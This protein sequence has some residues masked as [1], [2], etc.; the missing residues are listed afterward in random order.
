MLPNHKVYFN[1]ILS[2]FLTV[3]LDTV[4]VFTPTLTTIST[5][6]TLKAFLYYNIKLHTKTPLIFYYN[7]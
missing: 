3:F 1:Y 2:I 6:Y 4:S 7:I 5:P